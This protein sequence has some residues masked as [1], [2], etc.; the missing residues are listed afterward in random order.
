VTPQADADL[1]RELR[2]L[3]TYAARER[4]AAHDADRLVAELAW[5]REMREACALLLQAGQ[6]SW[7]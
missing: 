7:E 6:Q 1:I 3:R 2:A 4:K 5:H